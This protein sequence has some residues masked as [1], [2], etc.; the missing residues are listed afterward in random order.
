LDEVLELSDPEKNAL[1]QG[2]AF[3][4]RFAAVD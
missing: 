3:E 1:A 2:L 4:E